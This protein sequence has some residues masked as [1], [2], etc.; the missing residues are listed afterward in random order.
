MNKVL[1][2]L[3][4]IIK[5]KTVAFYIA[6]GAVV[7]AFIGGVICSGALAFAGATATAALLVTL[8]LILF[9]A[10]AVFGQDKIGAGVAAFLSYC[11]LVATFCDVFAYYLN[12]IQSQAMVGFDLGNVQ[13]LSALVAAVILLVLSAIALNVLAFLKLNKTPKKEVVEAE[14]NT[15]EI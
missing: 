4:N 1:D 8:G 7:I 10:S 6:L 15:N 2:Y 13:G 12:E 5:T 3:K 9:I 11:A 14:A